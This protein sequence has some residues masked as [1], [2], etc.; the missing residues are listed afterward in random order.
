MSLAKDITAS[1]KAG[2]QVRRP[3]QQPCGAPCRRPPQFR[4]STIVLRRSTQQ[5]TEEHQ[6]NN[7][8]IFKEVRKVLDRHPVRKSTV[9][10]T[11]YRR[12]KA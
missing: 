8:H 11:T 9:T 5:T 7:H 4:S 12:T 3:P 6:M 10:I 2:S 1:V